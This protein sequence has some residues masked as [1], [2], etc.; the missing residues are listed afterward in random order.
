MGVS[1]DNRF[2]PNDFSEVLKLRNNK[3][4]PFLLIGGQ[5]VNVWAKQYLHAEPDLAIFMPFTSTDID[6]KG[7]KADV[8]SI[9]TQ[10]GRIA[11]FPARVQMTALAGIIPIRI[12][13]KSSNIEVVRSVPGVN[14]DVVEKTAMT[15][16]FEGS[17]VRVINP[18]AL[19]SAKLT[20]ATSVSQ[21]DRQDVTHLKIMIL[22][23][24]GFLRELLGAI[25][26]GE[27]PPAGWLGAVNTLHKLETSRAGRRVIKDHGVDWS[28]LPIQEIS[29][30]KN[31]KIV[32]FRE[33]QLP[34][35]QANRPGQ[36]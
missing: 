15:F 18:I 25:E 31:P 32:S 30:A 24:R 17:S 27:I 2:S 36:N 22:C 11:K 10:L 19:V 12:G 20:S 13:E 6:F 7:N 1:D 23:A 33:I 34:R 16:E 21:E 35:W 29:N 9:A 3:G 4:D 14:S 5:A 8:T 26:K 28:Y